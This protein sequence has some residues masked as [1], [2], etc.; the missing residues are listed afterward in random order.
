ML[1][2]AENG[3]LCGLWFCGQ[4]HFPQND[5]PEGDDPVF[6]PVK[7]WLDGYFA[8]RITEPD[9][10]LD[11]RGTAFQRSVW[12]EL[13][14]IP[15]GSTA[16]Y[17]RIAAAVGCPSA[18]AVGGAVGRNPISVILP[19]HRVIGSDGTLT[20]YAGGIDRKTALLR[21]EKVID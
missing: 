17:G 15:A 3:A 12:R 2:A 8:G 10:P 11:P 5:W 6:A 4:K 7:N 18:R 19:C 9:F 20:G 14:R 13:L 16:T 1:L 21:L